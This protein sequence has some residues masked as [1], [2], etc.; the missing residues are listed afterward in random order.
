MVLFKRS[1]KMNVK[2]NVVFGILMC[3]FTVSAR[4]QNHFLYIQAADQQKFTLSMNHKN[5]TSGKTGYLIIPRVA[6][7][8][9]TVQIKK[10]ENDLKFAVAV[11]GRD[12]GFTLKN[13]DGKWRLLNVGTKKGIEAG[14]PAEGEDTAAG[15]EKAADATEENFV[16]PAE[17]SPGPVTGKPATQ[18]GATGVSEFARMLS[19]VTADP[20]LL[21]LHFE[22]VP[23]KKEAARL[24]KKKKGAKPPVKG[25]EVTETPSAIT[26]AAEEAGHEGTDLTFYDQNRNRVDTVK[27]FI[28]ADPKKGKKG[29]T[30]EKKKKETEPQPDPD[31]ALRS[32]NSTDPAHSVVKDSVSNPFRQA[33]SPR[34]SVPVRNSNCTEVAGDNDF[35]KLRKRMAAQNS[36]ALMIQTARKAFSARCYTTLQIRNLSTLFLNDQ[37]RFQFFQMAF[38]FVYDPANYNIL[39]DQLLDENYKERLRSLLRQ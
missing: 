6:D 17:E 15:G 11:K 25:A 22:S 5:Y 30:T 9:Y 33:V 39:E 37:T 7:G 27:V 21:N 20:S 32:T 26:K 28:P 23:G 31:L 10:G 4:T 16:K 14:A 8:K 24:D 38:A 3:F 36:D 2:L 29:V 35:V 12:Q 1:P 34:S 18:S 13:T 19:A